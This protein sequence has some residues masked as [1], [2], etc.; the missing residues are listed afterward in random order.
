[1]PCAKSGGTA[2]AKPFVLMMDERLLFLSKNL[3]ISS[4][5]SS[6][7]GRKFSKR[8]EVV[9][10]DPRSIWVKAGLYE[11]AVLKACEF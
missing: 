9:L 1:M 11:N 4:V 6:G 3:L 8:K 2:E 5:F 10:C 7:T